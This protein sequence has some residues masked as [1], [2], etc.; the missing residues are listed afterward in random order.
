MNTQK[1]SWLG[2][3]IVI[4]ILLGTAWGCGPTD[5]PIPEPTEP[6]GPTTPEAVEPP[7]PPGPTRVSE[8]SPCP[9]D[10]EEVPG[11]LEI[12]EEMLAY[13]QE[14][15]G[16][17]APL[18]EGLM[19]VP[20]QVIISGPSGAQ[21]EIER[22]AEELELTP[23]EEEPLALGDEWVAGLYEISD[24]K[25]VEETVCWINELGE[26]SEVV[27][28]PNY[29][30]SPAGEWAGAASPWTQN[31]GW[32]GEIPGG[33]QEAP[34]ADA[35]KAQWAL[36]LQS[37]IGLYDV[38][39]DRIP[40]ADGAG[41][42]IGI[43]D[44]SPFGDT[45]GK[46]DTIEIDL[47]GL[48][49]EKGVDFLSDAH[50]SW[51]LNVSHPEL[52]TATTCPG[53]DRY[54]D[55]LDRE[56]QDISSH[57]L[58]V[59]GLVHA[60]APASEIHLVR[61]LE[62]DGCGT[63]FS[64]AQGIQGFVDQAMQD[65]E[66]DQIRGIVLNLSLGVHQP[67]D[68]D[69]IC[70]P[71]DVVFLERVLRWAHGQGAVIVAAAGNDS[72]AEPADAPRGMELPAAYDFVIGVAASN[73]DHKRSCFSNF[74]TGAPNVVAPGGDGEGEG[75]C[76]LPQCDAGNPNACLVSLSYQSDTGYVYWVGTSFAAPLVTGQV[77]LNLPLTPTCA[78]PDSDL[79]G[80]I[81]LGASC[82]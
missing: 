59:A 13:E 62:D 81:Y 25:S 16:L 78:W 9:E 35:F 17:V 63:L 74:E 5:T 7:M 54:D 36:D 8:L 1:R 20:H 60:V 68:S 26:G 40:E 18:Y 27:G 72:Y 67:R 44:T 34:D 12:V 66:G 61:V 6:P 11:R 38:G 28:D 77:A 49:S 30:L 32:I 33:G 53:P 52:I 46:G 24:G 15:Q 75:D 73:I 19:Y 69:K 23:T 22:I 57:G 58:F 4:L 56:K 41:V 48:M 80:I 10:C 51:T 3:T 64:I 76:H 55:K 43:F 14:E 70:L 37:G 21:P 31:G 45:V 82:P 2:V 29:H 65:S 79:P 39:G 50:Q 71:N 42:R 47:A